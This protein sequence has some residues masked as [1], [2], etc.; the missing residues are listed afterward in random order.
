MVCFGFLHA[1]HMGFWKIIN[2]VFRLF[3][4]EVYGIPSAVAQHLEC[5]MSAK[6]LINLSQKSCRCIPLLQLVSHLSESWLIVLAHFLGSVF[7]DPYVCSY[8]LPPKLFRYAQL[9]LGL[10]GLPRGFSNW[11][12]GKL[13]VV[14]FCSGAP[15]AVTQAL[16][17]VCLSDWLPRI[18][19][20][21]S[22]EP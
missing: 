4:G 18:A 2:R 22:P 16:Y 8:T 20:K 17:L 13:Y 7:V 21:L 11:P 19:R 3:S 10:F 1:G 6:V 15:A 14:C 12:G 9:R 5:V